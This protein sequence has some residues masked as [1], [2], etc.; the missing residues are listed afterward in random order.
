MMDF[1][2]V[3]LSL[4]GRSLL[5]EFHLEFFANAYHVLL[6]LEQSIVN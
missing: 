3:S 2:G 4:K 6:A 5:S 1:K